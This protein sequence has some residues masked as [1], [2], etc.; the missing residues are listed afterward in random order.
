MEIVAAP[1]QAL[2]EAHTIDIYVFPHV[3]LGAGAT[4]IPTFKLVY[5]HVNAW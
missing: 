1:L 4:T 2:T 5:A 3:M